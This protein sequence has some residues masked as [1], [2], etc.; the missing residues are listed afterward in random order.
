MIVAA[1]LATF[2]AAAATGAAPDTAAKHA[3]EASFADRAHKLVAELREE[4]QPKIDALEARV[5]AALKAR[6]ELV[7]MREAREAAKSAKQAPAIDSTS[8]RRLSGTPT[9]CRSTSNDACS[10]TSQSCTQLHEYL[11]RKTATHTFEDIDTCLGTDQ[12]SWR[13]KHDPVSATVTLSNGADVASVATPLKV[14]HSPD[15]AS[16]TRTVP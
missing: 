6:D 5:A 2:K 16:H 13:A 4:A 1:C 7:A 11:E 8:G 14:T 3:T 9:C 15:C 10:T 12:T